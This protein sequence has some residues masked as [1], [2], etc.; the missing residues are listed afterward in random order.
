MLFSLISL[1][2]VIFTLTNC[3]DSHLLEDIRFTQKDLNINPYQGTEHLVF[4]RI[5]GDS[6]TFSSGNR[7]SKYTNRYQKRSYGN[8]HACLGDYVNLESNNTSFQSI[9]NLLR[10]N[11]MLY[12]DYFVTTPECKKVILLE[13]HS[14]PNKLNSTAF[15]SGVAYFNNDTI[16]NRRGT[17]GDSLYTYY[18]SIN[19]GPKNFYNVYEVYLEAQFLS[20]VTTLYYSRK[21]GIVGFNT[22]QGEKWYL[23][24]VF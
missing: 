6:M 10:F 22:Q 21:E 4:K 7:G 23:D 15:S 3:C 14:D 1:I 18:H 5:S 13:S 24:K 9:D 19:L 8:S 11:I 20:S 17:F 12:F 16:Y 2:A